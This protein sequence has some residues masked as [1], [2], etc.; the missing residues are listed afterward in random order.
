MQPFG[1]NVVSEDGNTG[2]PIA[3]AGQV[4]VD[5]QS[6]LTDIGRCI[7]R[8]EMRLQNEIPERIVDRFTLRIGTS[9]FGLGSKIGNESE[10]LMEEA[11]SR[12]FDTLNYL[13]RGS[14]GFWIE[15]KFKE[16][17]ERVTIA[18]D[19]VQLNDHLSGYVLM[20]GPRSDPREFRSLDREKILQYVRNGAERWTAVGRIAPDPKFKGHWTFSNSEKAVPLSMT[21]RLPERMVKNAQKSGAVTVL[22]NISKTPD[23]RIV[24]INNAESFTPESSIAFSRIISSEHDISLA[25]DLVASVEYVPGKNLWRMTYDPLGITVSKPSWDE[26]V[27]AFHEEFAFLYESYVESGKDYVGEDKKAQDLMLTFLPV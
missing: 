20:Y 2:V 6:L 16:P 24:S 15:E 21:K 5:I 13:G 3:V 12:L 1:F 4:M 26:C 18:R 8:S 19:L 17:F 9:R 14:S 7:I 10:A 23:G 27:M 22:G 25:A 11:L